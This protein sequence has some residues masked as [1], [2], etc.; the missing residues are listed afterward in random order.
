MVPYGNTHLKHMCY[1]KVKWKKG[2][3]LNKFKAKVIKV[4]GTQ[5]SLHNLYLFFK[6]VFLLT[7]KWT[8]NYNACNRKLHNKHTTQF[9]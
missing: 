5:L 6:Q 9:A 3:F 4:E 8:L 1:V 2:L 7:I